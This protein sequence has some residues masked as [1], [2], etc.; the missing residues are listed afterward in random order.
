MN[1]YQIESN[2]KQLLEMYENQEIDSDSFNEALN[3]LQMMESDKI[4]SAISFVKSLKA[5]TSAIKEEEKRLKE[6]RQ[7]KEK[8]IDNL[9]QYINDYMN[10]KNIK[11]FE[12]ARNVLSFRKTPKKVIIEDMA[13]FYKWAEYFHRDLL[14][15]KIEPNLTA[16]KSYIESGNEIPCVELRSGQI[17]SIK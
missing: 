6:R 11:K 4:D 3:N 2:I 9:M 8:T 17:L 7:T 13:E 14:K 15:E 12:T 5:E 10:R 1:L 16:I